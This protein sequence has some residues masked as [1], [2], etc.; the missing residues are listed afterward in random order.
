MQ[1]RRYTD[2]LASG[3]GLLTVARLKYLPLVIVLTLCGC[4]APRIVG[5]H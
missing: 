2:G 3:I 4:V 1:N 5:D